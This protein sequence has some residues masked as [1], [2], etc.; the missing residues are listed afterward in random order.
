MGG[1][2]GR[3]GRG[4]CARERRLAWRSRTA[5]ASN[6]RRRGAPSRRRIHLAAEAA[7]LLE[8]RGSCSRRVD[9]ASAAT[10]RARPPVR[11][12]PGGAAVR[13]LGRL[14]NCAQVATD[15]LGLGH[16]GDEPEPP[17]A[18]R[19]AEHVDRE[20]A[21]H[22]LCPRTIRGSGA[23]AAP[24]LRT[25]AGRR[26]AAWAARAGCVGEACSP[27]RARRRTS[28]CGISVAGPMRTAADLARS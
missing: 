22:E 13:S 3:T 9:V 6:R 5:V 1:S 28:R 18:A 4:G 20:R 10:K 23:V 19:A 25:P 12:A 11:R 16:Q 21:H 15:L 2:Q 7:P 26:Q 24:P 8:S 17:R 14:T 27:R